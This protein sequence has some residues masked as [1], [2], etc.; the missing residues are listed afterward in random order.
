MLA[1]FFDDSGTHASSPVV[2]LGGVL[3]TEDQ[4]KEFDSAWAA[5]LVKPIAGKP[6]LKQ[7]HLS[8]CRSGRGEYVSYNQDERDFITSEFRNVILGIG[9]VTIATAV[10]RIAWEE[11]VVGPLVEE[12]G[13]CE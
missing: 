3:G 4:W 10:D 5:L 8:A 9:F 12:L 1:A 11:L 2:V 6:P 13:Q 7:F